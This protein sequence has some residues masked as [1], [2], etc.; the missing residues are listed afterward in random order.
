[1]RWKCC[2]PIVERLTK[3]IEDVAIL[4]STDTNTLTTA[5]ILAIF[6]TAG[7]IIFLSPTLDN[8]KPHVQD[9][10]SNESR[11]S[12][13]HLR[14]PTKGLMVHSA[15]F[16]DRPYRKGHSNIT[17]MFI[18]AD[19]SIFSFN[20]IT[21]CGVGSKVSD[22]FLVRLTYQQARIKESSTYNNFQYKR[23][24]VECYDL[25]VDNGSRAFVN[26][27][28]AN[29]MPELVAVSEKAVMI[30]APRVQPTGEYNFTVATC[31]KI[32][33]RSA[34]YIPEFIRYQKTLG[35]DHVHMN[36]MEDFIEDGGFND[37]VME[38]PVLNEAIHKGYLSFTVWKN[39]YTNDYRYTSTIALQQLDCFYRF[40]GTYDY[41]SIADTDD[42]FTPRIPGKTEMKYYIQKH[43]IEKRPMAGSCKLK[44]RWIYPDVCGVTGKTGPDGNVTKTVTLPKKEK[45]SK[46]AKS[47]HSTKHVIDFRPHDADCSDCL[48]PGYKVVLVSPKVTYFVHNRLDSNENE[49]VCKRYHSTV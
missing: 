21:G 16:E 23:Y 15:H 45:Y 18:T 14:L 6:G 40:R 43:C 12:R 30:P 22:D 49:R 5:F 41:I 28:T 35:V 39:W 32:F 31:T 26:Y 1:M 34:N 10:T 13:H 44:W 9:E 46:Q 11:E 47:I 25:P 19:V 48:V 36:L 4:F 37:I 33:S 29:D 17:M 2:K 3:Q 20:W 27:K 38:D 24:V 7:L 42:F 8:C